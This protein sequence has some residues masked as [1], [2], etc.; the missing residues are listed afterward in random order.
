MH[1][2]RWVVA[3]CA[4]ASV[5][6]FAQSRQPLARPAGASALPPGTKPIDEQLTVV[7]QLAADPVA[8]V[9]SRAPDRRM[10]R[11][12]RERIA[13]D[14]RGGQNALVPLIEAR[15]G[16]VMAQ[17]Q[18]AIDGIKV[19]VPADKLAA[20]ATIP[21]VVA[22]KPVLTYHLVN[23]ESVPFIGA[24]AVWGGH[25]GFRGEGIRVAIIDTGVDYTHANFGGPGSIDAFNTA[26]AHS[27]E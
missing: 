15:G 9:R 16:R 18:H 2:H 5:P 4:L 3:L 21:G 25:P 24:G 27:T 8:V 10:E 17:F 12:E 11:A 6:V 1:L 22:V 20:L 7:L 14:L 19:R 23:S 13:S 26:F